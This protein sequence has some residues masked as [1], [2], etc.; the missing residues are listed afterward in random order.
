MNKERY[1]QIV[2]DAYEHFITK[3]KG[4]NLYLAING[5]LIVVEGPV[6]NATP[7]LLTQDEFTNKC[8]SDPEFSEKWGLKIEERELSLEERAKWL[9]DNK[10]Y[11]LLVGN[12]DHD[13]IL[14]VVEEEGPT[15]LIYVEYNGEKIEVYE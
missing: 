1:N 8:K 14:E 5:E 7:R 4:L 9:Q 12:L 11:D 13:H 6:Y 15:K 2:D 10:G 3:T